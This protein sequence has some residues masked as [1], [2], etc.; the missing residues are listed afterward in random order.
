MK[1]ENAKIQPSEISAKGVVSAPDRLGGT[2]AENKAVFDRL[3]KD[4]VAEKFNSFVDLVREEIE[5]IEVPPKGED[6][7]AGYTPQKGVDY[8]TEEDKTEI[9]EELEQTLTPPALT[10][11][12]VSEGAAA[13]TVMN[14]YSDGST[15]T[16]V[17]SFN[18]QGKPV[19]ITVDGAEIAGSWTEV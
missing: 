3:V 4:V 18:A 13:T 12:A 2:A 6:G 11:F 8:W 7:E 16:V 19:S 14:S 1:F 10:G 15:E 17:I 9:K 5:T